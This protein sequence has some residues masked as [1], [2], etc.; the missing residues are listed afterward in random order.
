MKKVDPLKCCINSLKFIIWW[1]KYINITNNCRQTGL[2]IHYWLIY[3]MKILF[4]FKYYSSFVA[5]I[6][7]IQTYRW[8]IKINALNIT[9]EL[10]L[11]C[12]YMLLHHIIVYDKHLYYTA[13]VTYFKKVNI[14]QVMRILYIRLTKQ[15]SLDSTNTMMCYNPCMVA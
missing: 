15:L 5:S 13:Y 8:R 2:L 14:K 9:I 3:T 10:K 6:T 7:Y 1:K 12:E 4:N 11:Y